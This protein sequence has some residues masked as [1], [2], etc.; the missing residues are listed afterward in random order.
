MEFKEEPLSRVH[1]MTEGGILAAATVVMA[2]I[3]IYVPIIG[4]LAILLWPLPVIVLVVRHGVR[5]GVMAVVVA[6][7][8]TAMIVEPATALRLAIA[9]G[10]VGIM[11]GL[12][13]RL[14]WSGV[15]IVVS[16]MAVSMLA[17]IAGLMLVFLL[18]GIEPF[19][20]QFTMMEESFAQ[21]ADMY[22]AM[23]V[24]ETQIAVIRQNFIE[25]M[26]IVKLL[27]P[28]IVM[29]M[30]LLDTFLNYIDGGKI[31]KRLGESVPVFPAF[32]EWR[33]PSAFLFAYAFSIIGLYWGKT[34]EIEMLFQISMNV[35]MA[36]TIAGIVEGVSLYRYAVR[37]HNWSSIVSGI[38]LV[39]IFF[40]GIL[41]NILALVGLL[42]TYFDYRARYFKKKTA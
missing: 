8:I 30:G 25:N 18:T 39:L 3:G 35:N 28:L 27:L 14:Q 13:Y 12:G 31:L 38:V 34:R 37:Y 23:G 10:P 42:D 21:T 22:R 32:T 6:S 41:L 20:N 24:N 29:L 5:W 40:G 7:L 33:L 17:K 16:C 11:L 9:F 4:M 2:M 36:C 1:S 26:A 15:K 19:G